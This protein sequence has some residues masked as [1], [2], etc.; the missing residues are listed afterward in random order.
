MQIAEIL[1]KQGY[2]II[3]RHSA[4][5]L[6]HWTRERLLRKRSCYKARFYGIESHRCLQ[7]TPSV[8]SCQHSCLFCWRP[9][10]Y[11]PESEALN[12]SDDPAYIARASI[13]AQRRLISG[14]GGE[15]ERVT[16]REVEEAFSPR[17][18][19]ISLAGE[20]TNYPHLGELISEYHRLGMTTFLVSNGMNPGAIERVS[21]T[22]LYITLTS[23]TEQIYRK[24]NRPKI[25]DGWERLNRSLEAFSSK[26]SRKVLRITLVKG[27]NL[28]V[29]EKFSEL[30]EKARPD[31]IEPK[32]Y[33][34][35]GYSRRRLARENMPTF[36][37]V[38][39]FSEKLA[40]ASGYS[41]KDSS[42]DSNVFLLSR[43]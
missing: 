27:Y 10:E 16:P 30:I 36:E 4:A 25:E 32:G 2:S 3:G 34:H 5:K 41:V 43:K 8:S 39:G 28:E 15:K 21:P 40:K 24:L 1:Q 26:S 11:T 17:N 19:A 14:Y 31:Y 22:S 37:D 23:P 33:V 20:P 38:R 35:V 42:R 29:P 6:C 12:E 7:M 13:E 18:V 9:A